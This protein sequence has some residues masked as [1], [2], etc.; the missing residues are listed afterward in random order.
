MDIDP[1]L[2]AVR[3]ALARAAVPRG[4]VAFSW[5]CV[6]D[7][8]DEEEEEEEEDEEMGDDDEEEEEEE[9]NDDEDTEGMLKRW[10]EGQMLEPE[11]V[12]E[13]LRARGVAKPWST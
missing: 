10:L 11:G 4:M 3:A 2:L 12:A 7:D 6:E 9:E 8:D 1:A 5:H 13:K